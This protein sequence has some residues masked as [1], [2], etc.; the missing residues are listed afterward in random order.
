MS[1][2]SFWGEWEQCKGTQCQDTFNCPAKTITIYGVEFSKEEVAL[3]KLL[4]PKNNDKTTFL[5]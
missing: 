1:A 5:Y 4:N 2:K 3:A